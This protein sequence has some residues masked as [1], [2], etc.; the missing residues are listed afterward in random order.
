VKLVAAGRRAQVPDVVG[1][2]QIFGVLQSQSKRL[3]IYVQVVAEPL[4][5]FSF[6]L[7]LNLFDPLQETP[8]VIDDV[9]ERNEFQRLA[10]GENHEVHCHQRLTPDILNHNYGVE[11]RCRDVANNQAKDLT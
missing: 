5:I 2:S 11:K 1:E 8:V 4:Q 9:V 10:Y 7:R 6:L 3:L